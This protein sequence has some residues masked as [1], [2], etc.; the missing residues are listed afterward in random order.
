MKN[1]QPSQIARWIG[2]IVTVGVVVL[3]IA[4]LFPALQQA[5]EAARRT[6]SKNNLKQIGLALHN[7]HDVY[8]TFPPGGV[9]NGEGIA[10]HG[11]TT[12]ITPFLDASPFYNQVNFNI[13]WDDPLQ[14]EHFLHARYPVLLNPGQQPTQSVDGHPLV[15]YSANQWLFHRNSSIGLKD[16]EKGTSN[17]L[18]IGN[19]FG[20][21]TPFGYPFN[22]RDPLTPINANNDGFG[23]DRHGMEAL[24]VD[25]SVKEIKKDMATEIHLSFAGP[26]KLRPTA[27]QVEKPKEPYRSDHRKMW[28]TVELYSNPAVH[29]ALIG[30]KNPD[31]QLISARFQSGEKASRAADRPLD[32]ALN[33]LKGFETLESFDG[34][35]LISDAGLKVLANFPNLQVLV[36]GGE[37]ITDDGLECISQMANLRE[38]TIS[39]SHVTNRGVRYL[40]KLSRLRSIKL[41]TKH[42]VDE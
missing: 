4:L 29:W 8:N 14:L 20:D 11:W 42:L 28:T 1:D 39:G 26:E 24:L 13:P 3:A 16:I 31:G 6:Q 38:L 23:Y 36:A 32:E 9:F 5:R 27:E 40:Q 10:F 35:Q 17:T 18:L 33:S 12:P 34:G 25:G 37:W 41:S 2:P 30:R 21:F 22:W 19:A 7:Y 15:H